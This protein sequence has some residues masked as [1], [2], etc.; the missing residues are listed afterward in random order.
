MDLGSIENT[1]AHN[2]CPLI[3]WRD[4]TSVSRSNTNKIKD[5]NLSR[6]CSDFVRRPWHHLQSVRDTSVYA[7]PRNAG[8]KKLSC[9]FCYARCKSYIS[10]HYRSTSDEAAAA[11]P[12]DSQS[13]IFGKWAAADK[14][15][16]REPV[17][18]LRGTSLKIMICLK[19]V[20]GWGRH[21]LSMSNHK[22]PTHEP[23]PH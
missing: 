14:R 10:P 8:R 21:L 19:G 1:L 3:I 4:P 15:I 13:V 12:D 5:G 11:H 16:S 22:H 20:S 7:K 9:N 2:I 17:V 6:V 23:A 18:L